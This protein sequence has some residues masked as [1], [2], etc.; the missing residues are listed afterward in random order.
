MQP[1]FWANQLPYPLV[2]SP[3][4][5]RRLV[6]WAGQSAGVSA[7][8]VTSNSSVIGRREVPPIADFV[9]RQPALSRCCSD[10]MQETCSYVRWSVVAD[11]VSDA[12]DAVA[13][14]DTSAALG[15]DGIL[16]ADEEED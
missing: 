2:T 15:E 4:T 7:C 16:R 5:C 11:D 13:V 6:K 8:D 12:A 1:G 3:A 14:V 9:P 10:A